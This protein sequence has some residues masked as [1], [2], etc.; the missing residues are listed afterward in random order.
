MGTVEGKTHGIVVAVERWLELEFG[1]VAL[2]PGGLLLGRAEPSWRFV[3]FV[4]FV[5]FRALV[6]ARWRGWLGRRRR[7]RRRGRREGIPQSY[8]EDGEGDE[9]DGEETSHG[10]FVV[11][12]D[13][14][15]DGFGGASY[16]T[17]LRR[18]TVERRM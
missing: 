10:F 15:E 16:R 13:G 1:I 4:K 12:V 18:L 8:D 6:G 17:L 5:K 9:Q 11:I 3:K 2:Q 14:K 7:R